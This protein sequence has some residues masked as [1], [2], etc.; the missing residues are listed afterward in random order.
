ME[1][2]TRE[3]AEA[4]YDKGKE[5]VVEVLMMMSATMARLEARIAV[6]ERQV[7]ANSRN[8]SKPP[9]SDGYRKPA[10]KSLRKKSGRRSGG[11]E[12]HPGNTLAMV[13][14]P[15]DVIEHW[16]AQCAGC[17]KYLS[18][19]RKQGFDAHQVH[20]LPPQVIEV[21]E[22]RAMKVC[23]GGCGWVT[24]G[25]F[26]EYATS[27]V[28]YGPGLNGLA[29]YLQAY[30]LIPLERTQELLRDTFGCGMSDGTLVNLR[31]RAVKKLAPITEQIKAAIN[32]TKVVNFDETGMRTEGKLWWL[33]S[34]STE[35][36]T[37]YAADPK[38]G[39]DAMDRINILPGFGGIAVHDAFS[40][41]GTYEGKH[42][43]CNAHVLREI[44]G[45]QEE[46]PTQWW[47]KR[48]KDLLVKMKDAVDRAK[49]AGAA[50][51]DPKLRAKYETN[52][53]GFLNQG[54]IF[55]KPPDRKPGQRGRLKA[56]PAHNL[57]QRMREHKDS[58]LRFL[59]D[60]S[61]PFDNNLAERDLRMM[62]VKQKISGTFRSAQ[63]AHAFAAVRG[64]VS[65][66]RKQG[67]SPLAALRALFAG[68]P[69]QI[70]L[71]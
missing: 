59:R 34:A 18:R 55:H 63:G 14:E 19:E 39:C 51:I 5:A 46:Y 13:A 37:H 66:V 22:H 8:S 26:P 36:L 20:D 49:A 12:G 50:E 57:I 17:G 30:Q 28:Q 70:Q 27:S 61:V 4:I 56:S 31:N 48:L 29:L 67:H 43:L 6:L 41:Y 69:M 33:H 60:F 35:T 71:G 44:T 15:D 62:K 24:R 16:P 58:V 9:S 64:Y 11:Q 47:L 42:A 25:N 54:L 38:R 23:C 7:A 65:T 1:A 2:L 53:S 45:L 40:S 32:R 52:Y 10:P 21:I 3:E 68:N